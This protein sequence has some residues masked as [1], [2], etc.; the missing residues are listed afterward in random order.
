MRLEAKAQIARG[1]L[2]LLVVVVTLFLLGGLV[3]VL[4]VGF[5]LNPFRETTTSFLV[6]AFLGLREQQWCWCS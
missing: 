3:L 2:S 1:T 4:C 5:N 6:A